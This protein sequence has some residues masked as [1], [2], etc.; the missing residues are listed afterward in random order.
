MKMIDLKGF[1]KTEPESR[2][3]DVNWGHYG[4]TDEGKKRAEAAFPVALKL[5]NESGHDRFIAETALREAVFQLLETQRR[6]GS[7]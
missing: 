2:D 6:K 5:V 1:T 3:F 4:L 7:I